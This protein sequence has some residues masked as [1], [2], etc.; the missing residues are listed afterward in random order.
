MC[1]GSKRGSGRTLMHIAAMT[2]QTEVFR[3]MHEEAKD[4]NP[5]DEDWNTPLHCAAKEG[6]YKI[7]K[8]II[9]AGIRDKN[10]VN[11]YCHNETP[12]SLATYNGH[13]S[14]CKLIFESA[15]DENPYEKY[16]YDELE[17]RKGY[18]HPNYWENN[19]P[20]KYKHLLDVANRKGF[21]SVCKVYWKNGIFS[22]ECRPPKNKRKLYQN[23]LP[24][25][26]R[27]EDPPSPDSSQDW[28]F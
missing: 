28:Y 10:P 3:K 24:I 23:V 12:L 13:A 1:L 20:K 18:F 25:D 7:C 14:V 5:K 2:G 17:P 8:L 11:D 22:D 4:K 26:H 27:M 21:T 6:H 15:G 9:D 16:D 19:C